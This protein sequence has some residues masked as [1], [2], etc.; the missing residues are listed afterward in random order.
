MDERVAVGQHAKALPH[1]LVDDAADLALVA[2]NGARGKDHRVTLGS[3]TCGCSSSAMRAMAP[4]GSP[5]LPV[6]S[7]TIF[8]RGK[9]ANELAGRKSGTPSR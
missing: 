5:W 8:S 1:K 4:R 9:F 2:G 6:A 7:N 3:F